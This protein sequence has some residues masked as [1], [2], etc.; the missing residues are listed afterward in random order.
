MYVCVCV[1]RMG[2]AKRS[3]DGSYLVEFIHRENML[4]Q[5]ILLMSGAHYVLL[6]FPLESSLT[7]YSKPL[8]TTKLVNSYRAGFTRC[9]AAAKATETAIC[10]QFLTVY[11][12]QWRLFCAFQSKKVGF[13]CGICLFLV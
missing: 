1:C 7:K 3:Q 5:V 8:P 4:L 2:C 10:A 12:L 13:N 11:P 6:L 9:T